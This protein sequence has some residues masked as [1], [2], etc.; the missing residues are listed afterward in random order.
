MEVRTKRRQI[1][2]TKTVVFSAWVPSALMGGHTSLD[3]FDGDNRWWGQMGTERLP[4][5]L[6]AL[7]A[8]SQQ[9]LEAVQRWQRQKN[10]AA[11]DRI[12]AEHAAEILGCEQRIV[13]GGEIEIQVAE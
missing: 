11:L 7:P 12:M 13:R 8:Y 6:E 5:E 4:P 3:R 10:E 1:I 2:G 9:R